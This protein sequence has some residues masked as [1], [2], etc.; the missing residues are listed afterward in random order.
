MAPRIQTT[1]KDVLQV[2][3][4]IR[5][6]FG[7]A[8][9]R[10]DMLSAGIPVY[11]QQ[12]AIYDSR[13]FRFFIDAKKH[14]EMQRFTVQ[15]N[16]LIISCSGTVGKVSKIKASDPTGIISQALLLLRVNPQIINPD[17]LKYF[18]LSEEGYN[19]I[20]SRS[21]GSVQ[22]NIAKREVIE[23]I[24][25]RLPT[26]DEQQKIVRILGSLDDKIELN[27][28]INANL[29]KQL[30]AVYKAWFQEFTQVKATRMVETQYGAI[31][32]GWRWDTLGNLC[33]SVSKTHKF[34]K[35]ELIFLNTGDIENGQFLHSNYTLVEGMP[36]QA[37][38]TIEQGDVLYSEIRPINRHFAYVNFQ[39]DDYVVSTKLMVIRAKAIDSRRLYHFLTQEKILAELQMQAE[40]RSGTFP[41]IR[42]DNV[43]KLPILIADEKT[44]AQFIDL[45]HISYAQIERNNLESEQLAAVRDA[46]LPRLMSGEIDVSDVSL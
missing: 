16:D 23:Q 30:N 2:K 39:A 17:Y 29:E 14:Q 28:R 4:Y 38:K 37:K 22:V 35:Q 24:P 36:G 10:N 9:K 13:V 7:S 25:L 44:E 43:G 11:E 27:R 18:F 42:F 1:L 45:L 8:L 20:V 3:G 32:T 34:D 6:P 5:G 26:L 40:S 19:A 46:A 12:H 41:Q 33:E 15:E 31:P 21:S